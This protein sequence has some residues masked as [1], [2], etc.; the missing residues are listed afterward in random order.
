MPE[1]LGPRPTAGSQS[2]VVV[3]PS[4]YCFPSPE[5]NSKSSSHSRLFG[6][7]YCHISPRSGDILPLDIRCHGVLP[8]VV[9]DNVATRS[10]LLT[11][12]PPAPPQIEEMSPTQNKNFSWG[13]A[14]RSLKLSSVAFFRYVQKFQCSSDIQSRRVKH[15]TTLPCIWYSAKPLHSAE[16]KTVS[17]SSRVRE[18]DDT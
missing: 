18:M 1:S 10:Q 15:W 2:L 17:S 6:Q 5:P 3:G 9:R 14:K 12:A 11:L 7:P 4:R 16:S 13:S 8:C